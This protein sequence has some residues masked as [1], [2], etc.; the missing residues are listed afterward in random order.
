MVTLKE[1][2]RGFKNTYKWGANIEQKI[3]QLKTKALMI[4]FLTRK[5]SFNHS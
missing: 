4:C 1:R 2:D 5:E 3:K